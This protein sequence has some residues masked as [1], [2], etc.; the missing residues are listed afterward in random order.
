M[1]RL[2]P[3]RPGVA[4]CLI[5]LLS[6]KPLAGQDA[7]AGSHVRA[8]DPQLLKVIREGRDQSPTFRELVEG[9]DNASG[10]VHVVYSRCLTRA[11]QPRACLDHNIRVSAG[12]RFLRVNIHPGESGATLLGLVAHEL[13]HALEVLADDTVTT[14]EHVERLYERIGTTRRSGGVE[15]EAALQVQD[16]VYR[17][18]RASS[19]GR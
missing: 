2:S 19:R 16:R 7:Q 10:I 15:T 3:L 4:T 8:E 13:Q 5:L 12:Y 17:E 6:G 14:S 1:S 11:W 9:I 18:A